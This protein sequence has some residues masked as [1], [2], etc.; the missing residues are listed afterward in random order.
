MNIPNFDINLVEQELYQ[1]QSELKKLKAKEKE[2]ILSVKE[3][4]AEDIAERYATKQEPFGAIT[5]A[6]GDI[7]IEV[8]RPKKVEWDQEGLKQLREKIS[9]HEDSSKY[10]KEKLTVSETDYKKW[11]KDVQE[12]FKQHRT[13]KDGTETI[14]LKKRESD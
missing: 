13:V 14:K 12:A 10:I 6:L 11:P 1:V 4:Y 9:K 3:Y 2:I 5:I 8:T 7:D